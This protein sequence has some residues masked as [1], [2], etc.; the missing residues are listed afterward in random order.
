MWTEAAIENSEANGARRKK[1][2]HHCCGAGRAI[3]Q[4]RDRQGEPDRRQADRQHPLL[5]AASGSA[6][7]RAAATT[8][9]RPHGVAVE[10]SRR[11][12][13]PARAE[14]G[15]GIRGGAGRRDVEG[16]ARGDP[17]ELLPM[18]ARRSNERGVRLLRRSDGEGPLLLRRP[19]PD[20]L[21]AAEFASLG[22]RALRGDRVHCRL[23]PRSRLDF[24]ELDGGARPRERRGVL[25]GRDPFVCSQSP[26]PAAY[27][28][29]VEGCPPSVF[30][31][32]V[33]S[34]ASFTSRPLGT[35]MVGGAIAMA[36][37]D[38]L[39]RKN[40]L[41]V[42]DVQGALTTAQ[43]SLISSPAVHGSL[44]GARSSA[45]SRTCSR[46]ESAAT[47]PSAADSQWGR[48]QIGSTSDA[49]HD[50]FRC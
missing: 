15:M 44:D 41:T 40:L 1:R 14:A 20:G 50:P 43:S 21:Q 34:N 31:S 24:S 11:P 32:S 22:R 4:R 17:R 29:F 10:A 26:F 47:G 48:L 38:L 46:A 39:V 9:D 45:R 42:D 30:G 37:L 25:R 12:R 13:H 3:A 35:A 36:I 2:E 27:T 5:G 18:A 6:E 7:H 28:V 8:R 33:M 16:G 19:L 23:R 49:R